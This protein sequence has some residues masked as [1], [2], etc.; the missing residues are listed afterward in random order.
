M[1]R[2]AGSVRASMRRRR[3]SSTEDP[4]R[5]TAEELERRLDATRERLR[6]EHPPREDA[7]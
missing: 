3:S 4:D 2:L 1:Q 5:R 6:R 7:G